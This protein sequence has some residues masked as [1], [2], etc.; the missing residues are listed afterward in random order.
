VDVD[1]DVKG[2]LLFYSLLYLEVSMVRLLEHVLNIILLSKKLLPSTFGEYYM[3]GSA[4]L[5]GQNSSIPSSPSI[6]SSTS[7]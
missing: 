3:L 4:D 2:T 7:I 1:V 5:I 6:H